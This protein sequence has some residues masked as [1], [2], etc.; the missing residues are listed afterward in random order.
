MDSYLSRHLASLVRVHFIA[1]D[2]AHVPLRVM[3]GAFKCVFWPAERKG[4]PAGSPACCA[5]ALASPDVNL[6]LS[7]TGLA[8]TSALTALTPP[9]EAKSLRTETSGMATFLE[10]EEHARRFRQM[11]RRSNPGRRG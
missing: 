11:G 9:S 4:E 8:V 10:V 6:V 5:H 3:E 2:V 7:E 1:L